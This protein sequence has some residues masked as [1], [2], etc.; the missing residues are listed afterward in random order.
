MVGPGGLEPRPLRGKVALYLV[1]SPFEG[2]C[3]KVAKSEISKQCRLCEILLRTLSVHS[4]EWSCWFP[5]SFI[6][7]QGSPLWFALNLS[8]G[9]QSDPN[10]SSINFDQDYICKLPLQGAGCPFTGSAFYCLPFPI[11]SFPAC[12]LNS[13]DG[14]YS[15]LFRHIQYKR[16][17]SLRPIATLAIFFRRRIG[18]SD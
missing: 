12:E 15:E 4:N 9:F 13:N 5:S 7:D 8:V 14:E 2:G 17:P 3:L 1:V 6:D 18:A 16:T 11:S 10:I